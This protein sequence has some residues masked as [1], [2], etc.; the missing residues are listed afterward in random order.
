MD[1]QSAPT[2]L[3]SQADVFRALYDEARAAEHRRARAR[4]LMHQV[5]AAT[6]ASFLLHSLPARHCPNPEK[7]H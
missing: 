2:E 1:S 7:R 3:V 6:L 4:R 5:G